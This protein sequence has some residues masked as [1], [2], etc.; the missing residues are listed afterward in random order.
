MDAY[1]VT[2][3]SSMQETN[4]Y[5]VTIPPMIKGLRLLGK[6]LEK[7]EAHARSKKT[8]WHDYEEALLNDRLVF[9]QFP[10]VRQVQSVCDSAK[11]LAGKLAEIEAP[12]HPDTEKSFAE[13]QARIAKTIHFLESI[14]P[15]KVIG[16]ENIRVEIRYYPGKYITGFDYATE[17]A[18]PNYY[19][20]LTTAYAIMRKDGVNLGKMDYLGGLSLKDK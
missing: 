4:L 16:K 7:A 18:L 2:A 12:S 6:K 13:L 11:G 3:L 1:Q 14:K 20:H 10:L 17:Y 5:T 8:E 19:F 9:D 15:E